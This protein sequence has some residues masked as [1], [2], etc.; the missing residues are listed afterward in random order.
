MTAIDTASASAPARAAQMFDITR[1]TRIAVLLTAS[2]LGMATA[3]AMARGLLGL[4][5]DHSHLRHLAVVLHLSTVIP[6]IPLG[7]YLLLARKGGARHR[8]LGRIWIALMVVTALS[9]LAIKTSG[10]FSFIHLLVPLTL[11][12]SYEVVASARRRDFAAHRKAILGLFFGAL[13]IP[14][15]FALILP[16]RLLSSLLFG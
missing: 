12:G 8:L 10:S 9:A 11:W 2:V 5:P 16:G 14:G 15:I 1:R 7:G 3:V 6:A 13:T 4:A